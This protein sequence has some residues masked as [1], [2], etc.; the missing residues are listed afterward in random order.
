MFDYIRFPLKLTFSVLS[1]MV[2]GFYL[3]LEMPRWA[4]MTAGIVAGGTAFAAGGDPYSGALR[5]RGILRIVGTFFGSVAALTLIIF[6]V[7]APFLLMLLACIWAGFCVWLSSLARIENASAMATASYTALTVIVT[8]QSSGHLVLAPIYA[9]ERCS[10]IVLGILCT[11]LADLIFSPRSIKQAIDNEADSLLVMHYRLLRICVCQHDREEVDAVWAELVR[12]THT[13]RN[14]TDQLRLESSRWSNACQRLSAIQDLSLTLITHAIEIFLMQR[15]TSG[16]IPLQYSLLFEKEAK[17]VNDIHSSMKVLRH[18]LTTA[19]SGSKPVMLS[20]WVGAATEYLLLLNGVKSNARIFTLEKDI[21]RREVVKSTRS[22]ETRHA[23]INGIRTFLATATA[24][25]F[26][27]YTGWTSGSSCMILLGVVTALAMRSPNPLAVAKDFVYGMTV[28]A[29]VALVIYTIILPA[30]QQ[31]MTLLCLTMGVVAFVCGLF[32]QKRQLG[33]MGAFAGILNAVTIDNPMAFHF[34]VFLDNVLGQIIGSCLALAV[35]L[36]IPDNARKHTGRKILNR[37]MYS[38]ISA[39]GSDKSRRHRN[40]LP[41]MYQQLGLLQNLFPQDINKYRIAL[42]LI[43]SYQQFTTISVQDSQALSHLRSN[44]RVIARR[45]VSADQ[46][47]QR[48][49]SFTRLM[50][51][52][53]DYLTGSPGQGGE[54]SLH[55]KLE[56]MVVLL[57]QYEDS[58]IYI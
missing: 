56:R 23:M 52:L 21:L 4:I 37:L 45:L 53:K 7:Q 42:T 30:T 44:L 15:D 38:A 49:E 3:N 54:Q 33:T 26:W 35:I 18:I 55:Q 27:L 50:S 47:P 31:S 34:S 17:G 28:A 11:M 12:R 10:E 36:L 19:D 13:L 43:L 2:I 32:L 8:I 41:A 1:A 46:P 25:L 24:A 14:M 6:T 58:F 39:L 57:E 5:Y 9:I 51:E 48:R 29:P 16:V 40:H 22:A 20:R